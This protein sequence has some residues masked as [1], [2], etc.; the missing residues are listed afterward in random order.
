MSAPHHSSLPADGVLESV[1]AWSAFVAELNRQLD[2]VSTYV[3]GIVIVREPVS[4]QVDG[5]GTRTKSAEGLVFYDEV[6]PSGIKDGVNDTFYLPAAPSPR[7]S[8]I[9]TLNLASLTRGKQ[10][11]VSDRQVTIIDSNFLPKSGDVFR[12]WFRSGS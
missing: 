2:E 6:V 9:L 11:A 1:E 10:F 7:E 3:G 5:G 12:C 4:T 8:T